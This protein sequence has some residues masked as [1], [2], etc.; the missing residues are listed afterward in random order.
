VTRLSR[1]ERR[2]AGR[3]AAEEFFR[4][5]RRPE[6]QVRGLEPGPPAPAP[7]AAE[8]QQ[9]LPEPGSVLDVEQS[10]EILRR[11][12]SGELKQQRR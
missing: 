12:A 4:A 3:E 7:R 10:R 11:L 9:G 5:R 8:Q 6:P 2:R 1:G